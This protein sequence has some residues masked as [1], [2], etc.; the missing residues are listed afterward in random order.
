VPVQEPACALLLAGGCFG[1]VGSQ[2]KVIKVPVNSRVQTVKRP[3]GLS[4]F[5][6]GLS[7]LE[8]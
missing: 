8:I 2:A 1:F 3:V 6:L 5:S 4:Q 7:G